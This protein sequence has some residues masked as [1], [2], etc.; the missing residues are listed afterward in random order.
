MPAAMAELA[1][2]M[3]YSAKI[4]VDTRLYTTTLEAQY[5]ANISEKVARNW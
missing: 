3:H 2:H 4:L 5:A 1:E